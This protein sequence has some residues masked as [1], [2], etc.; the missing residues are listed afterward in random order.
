VVVNLAPAPIH[1]LKNS[2]RA[3]VQGLHRA[4]VQERS[5]L[6]PH[7]SEHVADSIDGVIPKYNVNVGGA[8][9]NSLIHFVRLVRAASDPSQRVIDRDF[10]GGQKIVVDHLQIARIERLIELNQRLLWLAK[11]LSGNIIW[12]CIVFAS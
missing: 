3:N 7:R 11:S 8:L 5:A 10:V 1:K 2:R 6:A 12:N 4:A 9:E